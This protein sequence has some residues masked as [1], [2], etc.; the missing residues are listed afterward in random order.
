MFKA[1]GRYFRALGYLFTGQIDSARK[2][3]NQN[4]AVVQATF[5]R[6]IE[7]KKKIRCDILG[8]SETRRKQPVHALWADGSTVALGAAEE[9]RTVGGVGFIV[10]KRWAPLIDLIDVTNPRVGI[11]TLRL[12]RKATIRI[13]QV[14]AP[15]SAAEDDEI[16]MFYEAVQAAIAPRSTY[17]ILMG[18]FNAKVDRG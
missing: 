9:S 6:I 17:L 1:I 4:P 5:D 13:V 15:T 2:V 3:L 11:L 16:E 12:A 18:D 7:E 14:Y 8:V 10:S